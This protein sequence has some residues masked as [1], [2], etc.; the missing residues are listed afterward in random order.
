M[1]N[2]NEIERGKLETQLLHVLS[3]FHRIMKFRPIYLFYSFNYFKKYKFRKWKMA[4]LNSNEIGT[5][6]I[7]DQKR[8][9]G[10]ITTI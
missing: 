6:E 1:V 5:Y 3:Y 10:F 4:S 7:I 2:C 9:H 8:F